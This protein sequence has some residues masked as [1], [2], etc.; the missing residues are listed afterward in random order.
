MLKP[1]D[2]TPAA[3]AVTSLLFLDVDGVLNTSL[4]AGGA[5]VHSK[6]MKHLASIVLETKCGVILSSTWRLEEAYYHVLVG[7]L[8]MA[9]VSATETI[10]G[11][12]PIV[13]TERLL[14]YDGT[15]GAIE[16]AIELQRCQ[17]VLAWLDEHSNDQRPWAVLDDL[18]LSNV[19]D[20]AVKERIQGHIVQTNPEAGLTKKNVQEVSQ[21]LLGNEADVETRG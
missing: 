9:G 1:G 19:P 7:A 18:S 3:D 5:R 12:T 17:E 16:G 8:E 11:F 13:E 14:R 4:M 6:L 21:I 15:Y 2:A 10:V 20:T